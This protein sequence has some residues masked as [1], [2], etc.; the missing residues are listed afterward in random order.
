MP[1]L[2]VDRLLP[3]DL[4]TSVVSS[5]LFPLHER[6]KHHDSVGVRKQMEHDQWLPAAELRALQVARLRKH[7][8]SK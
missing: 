5:V 4:Y 3:M 7:G 1:S 2:G 8:A 6:L